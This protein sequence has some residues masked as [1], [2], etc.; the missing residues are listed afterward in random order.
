MQHHG[1][2]QEGE[3]RRRGIENRGKARRDACLAPEDQGEG[4]RIVEQ[5]HDEEACQHLGVT[6]KAVGAEAQHHMQDAGSN[7]HP[8]KYQH[9]GRDFGDRHLGKKE[10]ATP[11]G[12]EEKQQQ[13]GG[14]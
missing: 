14:E 13:P 8:E 4:N 7:Q 1:S 6:G 12:T 11:Q 3:N 2:D 5:P 9:Q 10:G